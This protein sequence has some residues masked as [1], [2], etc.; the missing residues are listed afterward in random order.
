MLARVG[1]EKVVARV[2]ELELEAVM[3]PRLGHQVV[4]FSRQAAGIERED[5]DWRVD[6]ID[7]VGQH[8][9]LGTEAVGENGRRE[10]VGDARE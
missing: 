4:G 5:L 9:V 1:F 6:G 7:E 8:H 10:L 3:N 2:I